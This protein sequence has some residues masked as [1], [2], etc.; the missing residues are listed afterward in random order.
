MVQWLREHNVFAMDPSLTPNTHSGSSVQPL[1]PTPRNL[2]PSTA[3]AWKCTYQQ[4]DMHAYTEFL[5]IAFKMQIFK[6]PLNEKIQIVNK[7]GKHLASHD[8]LSTF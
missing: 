4:T 1:I 8:F 7:H 6:S 2:M 5:K 3:V